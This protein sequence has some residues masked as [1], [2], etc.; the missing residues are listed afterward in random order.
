MP[1]RTT[2][3]NYLLNILINSLLSHRTRIKVADARF[4]KLCTAI[5]I[6]T[7]FYDNKKVA[8]EIRSYVKFCV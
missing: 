2:K 5:F 4:I 1:L 3:I 7:L 8:A 6:V